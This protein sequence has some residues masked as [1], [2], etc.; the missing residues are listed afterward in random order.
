[1]DAWK[2][3]GNPNLSRAVCRAN[4]AAVLMKK[5]GLFTIWRKDGFILLIAEATMETG[6]FKVS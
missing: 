2:V 4:T 5:T 1:M 6:D 3:S